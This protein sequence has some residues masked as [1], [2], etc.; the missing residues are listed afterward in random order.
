[1]SMPSSP[2][3]KGPPPAEKPLMQFFITSAPAP[4]FDGVWAAQRKWPR[5]GTLIAVDESR[6]DDLS[7]PPPPHEKRDDGAP[8]IIGKNSWEELKGNPIQIFARP[9][10]DVE[11]I[12]ASS[13][14]YAEAR[15]TITALTAEKVALVARVA[16]L[17]GL[18]A[19][20]VAFNSAKSA[21]GQGADATPPAPPTPSEP[22][23]P[24]D[25]PKKKR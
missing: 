16:E 17:E 18:L 15:M 13:V 7:K 23:A 3:L 25:A 19:G 4:G 12:A 24:A 22:P 5:T 14:A 9:A 6:I 1:M 10:G 21:G 8:I 11:E 2:A 20:A